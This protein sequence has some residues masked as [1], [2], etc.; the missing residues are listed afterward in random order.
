MSPWTIAML[1]SVLAGVPLAAAAQTLDVRVTWRE[2]LALPAQSIIEVT[3]EDVSRAD[4]PAQVIGRSVVTAPVGPPVPIQITYDPAEIRPER[5]YRV[6][7]QIRTADNTLLFTSDTVIPVLTEGHGRAADIPLVRA[8]GTPQT[9]APL[10][11]TRWVATQLLSES[12]PSDVD[13]RR[14]PDL[15]LGAERRVSGTDGCNR[16]TGT[17]VLTGDALSFGQLASTQMACLDAGGF[18]RAYREAL[19]AARRWRIS[20]GRLELLGADAAVVA[21]FVVAEPASPP[22]ASIRHQDRTLAGTAWQLV[23]FQGGDDT[24][25]VPDDRTK[26]T[27]AFD[28][29][30]D[31]I[32]MRVDCNRGRGT[33]TSSGPSQIHFGPLVMTRAM[34]APGSMHDQIVRQW[35]NVRSYVLRDGRLF[36]SL[37]ADG[38]IYKFEAA[39]SR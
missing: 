15:L 18:E 9:V 36:L 7:A 22:G 29:A 33:W 11:G 16:V 3:L 23:R 17:F 38:G 4:G 34:C 26:Y 32:T 10:E 19:A 1:L 8:G 24:V 13:P 25:L 12:V 20:E 35:G 5:R 31:G 6:R 28:M 37:M 21:L 27:L 2:R 30:G 39:A 14:R